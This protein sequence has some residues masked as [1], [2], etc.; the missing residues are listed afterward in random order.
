MLSASIHAD[1]RRQNQR[2]Q[3]QRCSCLFAR[4]SPWLDA[5]KQRSAAR[6]HVVLCGALLLLLSTL[7]EVG[8]SMHVRL[9]CV[10]IF[11]AFTILCV[12]FTCRSSCIAEQVCSPP[13][14]SDASEFLLPLSSAFRS[15]C[16]FTRLLHLSPT[17]ST[18]RMQ[19]GPRSFSPQNGNLPKI[20][21]SLHP[22]VPLPWKCSQTVN[23]GT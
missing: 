11:H 7:A 22:L 13:A 8:S 20:S 2:R 5:T 14:L 1:V 9:P 15:R 19:D 18:L 6:S 12:S 23:S 16:R 17:F 3:N 21:P 4:P 10:R